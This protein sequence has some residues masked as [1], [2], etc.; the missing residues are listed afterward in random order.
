MSLFCVCS[1][2][3]VQI[4]VS[5]ITDHVLN[6]NRRCNLFFLAA[7]LALSC[8]QQILFKKRFRMRIFCVCNKVLVQINVFRVT[9]QGLHR[10]RHCKLFFVT[11]IIF[12]LL[13]VILLKKTQFWLQNKHFLVFNKFC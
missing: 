5:H 10:N 3:L 1:K 6:R 13:D 2:V 7:K 11:N 12:L 4:N 9:D 8:F